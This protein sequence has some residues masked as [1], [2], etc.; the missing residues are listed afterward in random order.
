MLGNNTFF[1][2]KLPE[3][4]T[5]PQWLRQNGYFTASLGKIFHRGLTMEDK[6]ADWA[7]AKS[8][9]HI[10]IYDATE[11]GNRGEGRRLARFEPTG[12]TPGFMTAPPPDVHPEFPQT[13]DLRRFV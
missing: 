9:E 1:R 7:D 4:V 2:D 10:R 3:I 6:R 12:H 13:L 5:L 8:F 11:L